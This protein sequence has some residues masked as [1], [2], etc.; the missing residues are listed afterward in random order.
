M[1]L[2]SLRI[3]GITARMPIIQG[4]MAVRISMAKL[5]A[6]VANEGG[7]GL[8]AAS[9]IKPPELV[10]N[11]RAARKL[12]DGIIGINVMVAVR[13]FA[14]LV[15]AAI[16]EG[17][18]LIVAG[19]GFSRD[20]FKWCA[21][22]KV[23]FV[24]IIS[25]ERAAKMAERL[26][27]SAVILEGKEAGGHLGTLEPMWDV[28]PGIIRTVS[29]PVI[30]AGGIL[31]GADIAKALDMGA[32]GVQMG[33][34]FAVSIES[35]AAMEW[36]QACVNARPEDVVLVESPVGMPARAL[37]NGFVKRLKD[38]DSEKIK[39]RC[40]RCL[41]EC[42]KVYCVID[43]LEKARQGDLENGLIF[44]GERIGEIVKI[45]SVKEIFKHLVQEY[46]ITRRS[47]I[48]YG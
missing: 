13:E 48:T 17:I 39:A 32:S 47:V 45:L 31:T 20:A 6:A 15:Q 26:G 10:E 28:L 38:V 19:A 40:V 35:N 44:C 37:N 11:I 29:V 14:N 36:K 23:P 1:S 46:E 41:K 34:R 18:D 8:I 33:S 4:G 22:A 7:I 30:A 12:T 42:N 2:P 21:E 9:G 3:G 43:A 5:A 25:S 24:P 16:R 27:A